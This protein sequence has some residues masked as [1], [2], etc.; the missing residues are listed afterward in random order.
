MPISLDH[1]VHNLNH[2][3]GL[4]TEGRKSRIYPS[5]VINADVVI[6][7]FKLKYDNPG[8]HPREVTVNAHWDANVN[9]SPPGPHV[10]YRLI[11]TLN[12]QNNTDQYSGFVNVLVIAELE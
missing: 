8:P 1:Q 10:D 9:V 12:E 7:G 6:S 3:T 4:F 2:V 11:A 5:K